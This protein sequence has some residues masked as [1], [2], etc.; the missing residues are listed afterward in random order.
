MSG[1]VPGEGVRAPI[2]TRAVVLRVTPVGEADLIFVLLTEEQGR[3][4]ARARGARKSKRRFSGGVGVAAIGVATVAR[5]RG[6]LW[7]LVEFQLDHDR[8]ALGRD[9]EAFAWAG[10]ACE[11]SDRLLASS[12]EERGA[13]ELVR[14]LIEVLAKGQADALLLRRLELGLLDHAGFRPALTECAV[15]GVELVDQ[16]SFEAGPSDSGSRNDRE[17]SD[18]AIGFDAQRGGALCS[19]HRLGAGGRPPRQLALATALLEG[20]TAELRDLSPRDR[21]GLR[22]LC[23][24]LIR[25]HLRSELKSLALLSQLTRQGALGPAIVPE[26]EPESDAD[27]GP[28]GATSR[29]GGAGA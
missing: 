5:A 15:C 3:L 27:G 14:D 6:E 16:R 9:L 19:Q 22:D 23:Q 11:L 8:A 7:N 18:D 24:L 28:R 10:Y 12:T 21:R 26:V 13:F 25:P 4:E 17:P 1:Y 20:R 2:E 29:A